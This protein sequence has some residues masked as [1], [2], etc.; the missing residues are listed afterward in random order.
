MKGTV[1]PPSSS[2]RVRSICGGRSC[3]SAAICVAYTGNVYHAARV[4]TSIGKR[5]MKPIL[6]GGGILLLL[7]GLLLLIAALVMYFVGRNKQPVAAAPYRPMPP[8]PQH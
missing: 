2:S 1:A 8:Q 5:A 4:G 7:L 3:S 6:L